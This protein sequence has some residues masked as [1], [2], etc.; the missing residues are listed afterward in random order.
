[1]SPDSN[2]GGT[3]ENIEN[4]RSVN[5]A[6]DAARI[7]HV[8]YEAPGTAHEFQTWRK[9]LRGFTQLIFK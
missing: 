9:S 5:A 6:L 3:K 2:S 1:M 4:F 7:R 8:A